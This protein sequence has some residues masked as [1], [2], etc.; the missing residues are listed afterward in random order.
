MPAV[1]YDVGGLGEVVDRVRGGTGRRR[2][3]TSRRSQR[4]LRELLDDPAALAAAR[5]GATSARETLT[6]DAAAAAHLALYEELDVRLRRGD[7]F[8][9]LVA[10]QLDLF[11][12]DE[13]DLLARGRRGGGR[14]GAAG[15]DDAEEAYGDYQLVV[16]AIADRL[17]DIRESYAATLDDGQCG[18]VP[19]CVR[20][21]APR[22]GFALRVAR[23]GP[24]QIAGRLGRRLRSSSP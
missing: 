2:R 6:W 14:V 3:A 1:V 7:P 9:E 22:A 19:A 20:R 24:R 12:E 13:S 11:A 16:D 23:R 4:A 21:A 10:R 8:D 15:R 18:R 17:L 5:E